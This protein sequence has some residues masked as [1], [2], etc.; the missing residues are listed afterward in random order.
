MGFLNLSAWRPV[1][2]SVPAERRA[3]AAMA[4]SPKY[5]YDHLPE[6][7]ATIDRYDEVEGHRPAGLAELYIWQLQQEGA[8]DNDERALDLADL[9][10]YY[11]I[12]QH[13]LLGMV[14]IDPDKATRA[15]KL[16]EAR[17][18]YAMKQ[19]AEE[20]RAARRAASQPAAVAAG[21]TADA[22]TPPAGAAA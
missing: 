13:S 9:M 17:H 16:L 14:S 21:Q 2:G 15:R 8:L 18:L 11:D 22:G 1:G 10:A 5:Y 7:Q 20:R 3:T 12:E 19:R 4:Q 6:F